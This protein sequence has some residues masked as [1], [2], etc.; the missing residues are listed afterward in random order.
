MNKIN[1]LNAFIY[2]N[3]VELT[4]VYRL[5]RT[6]NIDDLIWNFL[7]NRGSND[8]YNEL[9]GKYRQKHSLIINEFCKLDEIIKGMTPT[10]AF[11][12]MIDM[13]IPLAETKPANIVAVKPPDINKDLIL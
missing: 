11:K 7:E 10:K 4:Q 12:A 3:K 2:N 6:V 9:A 5:A 13:G 1:E 8:V